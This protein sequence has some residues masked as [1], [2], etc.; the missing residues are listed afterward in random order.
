[1]LNSSVAKSN[2][3]PQQGSR[4]LLVD[5]DPI[6]LAILE[7]AIQAGGYDTVSVDSAVEGLKKLQAD[8]NAFSAVLLDRV[9]PV[10]DGIAMLR[11]I[12]SDSRLHKLPVILQ[13]A[14]SDPQEIIEGLE[15]G[16]YYYITKPYDT[17]LLLPVVH[18]AV[19]EL[20]ER[21]RLTTELEKISHAL[22]FLRRGEFEAR[23][24]DDA[25][26]LAIALAGAFPDS[27]RVV[28][29]LT[30]LLVNAVE[31]GNAGITYEDKS[32]LLSSGSWKV[33]VERRLALKHNAAKRVKVS[34]DTTGSGIEI[35]IRDEGA[36]FDWK[37]Y[38]NFSSERA[39]DAH[40]RG[41]AMS[42]LIS[43]DHMEYRG[44]GNEVL[45][46]VAA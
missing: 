29:G 10:M 21:K 24:L 43:F 1:M 14:A 13:T 4:L 39:C 5:D 23:T 37:N 46:R 40:G 31:H 22:K 36:G 7:D 11:A 17:A 30:E 18:A 27:T 8:P 6:N 35:L 3:V 19:G 33:E 44:C 38:L 2:H 34:M 25:R 20:E 42:R 9:M 32:M 45:V 26:T 12:K 28:T 41:I 15:A 16:A